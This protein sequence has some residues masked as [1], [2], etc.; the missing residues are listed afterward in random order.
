[1]KGRMIGRICFSLICALLLLGVLLPVGATAASREIDLDYGNTEI[2]GNA[3]LSAPELLP[4]LYGV[5]PSQ[6]EATYLNTQSALSFSYS[7]TV[8]EDVVSTYYDGE[9]GTLDVQI[10]P[11]SFLASSGAQV[12]WTPLR[13]TIE[14]VTH[15][16]A[17]D[18]EGYRCRFTDL[19]YS[20]D[21]PMSV[22][23]SWTVQIP[24]EAGAILLNAAHE[25]G[26]D[27]L[28][29]LLAYDAYLDAYE[30]QLDAYNTRAEY[31]EWVEAYERYLDDLESYDQRKAEYDA[32]LL[33]Y[34][35]YLEVL[36]RYQAWRDYYKYLDFVAS[37]ETGKYQKYIEYKAQLDAVIAAL[38]PLESL[39]AKD[40]NGWQ[41]YPSLMGSSVTQV[42]AEKELLVAAGC[43]PVHI[44]NAAEATEVLRRVMTEYAELRKVKYSSDH[45]RYAALWA[46]YTLHYTELKENFGKLYAS[47]MPVYHTVG[48]PEEMQRRGRLLRFQQFAG[49][50]YV[51]ATALDDQSHRIAT[52]N[53]SKKS[54]SQV[55]EEVN[56]VPDTDRADPLTSNIQMPAEEVEKVEYASPA[57][58]PAFKDPG[59]EPTP[60]TPVAKPTEP[61]PVD[62]P[63]HVAPPAV[64][65]P[66]KLQPPPDLSD[67][68]LAV[69]EDVRAGRLTRREESDPAPITFTKTISHMVS[70]HNLLTVTFYDRDAKTVL[71]RQTLE[72]GSEIRVRVQPEIVLTPEKEYKFLGW[73]E[74]NGATADLTRI[75]KN[76]SLYAKYEEKDRY[77]AV[78]WLLDDRD[79]L[80]QSYRWGELPQ[81]PS[82]PQKEDTPRYSYTFAGWDREILPVS[83]D[84]TYVGSFDAA[85]RQYTVTWEVNGSTQSEQYD[86]GAIPVYKGETPERATGTYRYT[87]S[88][89][90]TAGN[91][92]LGVVK[93]DVTYIA[94]FEK[95]PLATSKDGSVYAVEH[96]EGA[97][98][99]LATQPY[100]IYGE[101]MDAAIESGKALCVSWG[102]VTL[103]LD[104]EALS[105]LKGS[106]CKRID[107][108]E[109]PAENGR[110]FSL[111]YLTRTGNHTGL[112]V[113]ATFLL[114]DEEIDGR[115]AAFYSQDDSAWI[116]YPAEK[117][118]IVGESSVLVRTGYRTAVEEVEK[119]DLSTFPKH[120]LAG[121]TVDLRLNCVYGYAV[122]FAVV[123][124]SDGTE[125][126]V[127]DLCFVM[128]EDDVSIELTVEKIVY[129]VTFKVNGEVYHTADY[130]LDEAIAL[131]DDP[132][133]P[134][135]GSYSYTF[136]GWS[137][138]VTIAAG[139]NRSPVYEAQ[140]SKLALSGKDPYYDVGISRLFTV[141]LPIALGILLCLTLLLL[142]IFRWS[143]FG[144][145]K[146]LKKQQRK[147]E[148][149]KK[150]TNKNGGAD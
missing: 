142:W 69:A 101:A 50:L 36:A 74:A 145:R 132:T 22:D 114:H 149:Q 16:L 72:Y 24:R 95:T 35:D 56:L 89:W 55:V 38:A 88:S 127:K 60:P 76:R 91:H 32:Y 1:M 146:H 122:S 31:D 117:M 110:L 52:W 128:P 18:G 39:F 94:Q 139:E 40:S 28:E 30:D 143:P 71:D 83:G 133:L 15:T 129:H 104:G 46:F 37:Q 77:Y 98:T 33:E 19:F 21:Y 135:D 85:L 44:D 62:P 79:P 10:D 78:T 144:K 113:K 115:I 59:V 147:Q 99:V 141:T 58:E 57:E 4:L 11:Y 53:I 3:T 93:E 9:A 96:S 64:E 7:D 136:V 140:F 63:P 120:V 111:Q 86:Y 112:S 51:T 118:E 100:V 92:L 23:F 82:V 42:L 119:C 107:L 26:L 8:P 41:F 138:S 12:T 13:V 126:E 29:Q 27:A 130:F 2:G 25:D 124:R 73:I 75:T 80:V 70:I 45:D 14:G 5:S 134:S 90:K 66:G 109:T 125:V 123:K 81:Y 87:F 34:D 20:E 17:Q 105:M 49:Q 150:K 68:L 116:E 48:V 97:I 148:K 106:I 47:L 102:R 65:H 121:E 103:V 61:V 67:E 131:P 54:L 137:P 84:T 108:K 43:D 6:N